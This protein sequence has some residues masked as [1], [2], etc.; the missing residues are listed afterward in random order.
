MAKRRSLAVT[1]ILSLVRKHNPA[2]PEDFKLLGIRLRK[3]GS[4]AFRTVYEIRGLPLV[5]KFP[6]PGTDF[7]L[8][9]I[10]TRTELARIK[11]FKKFRWMRKHLPRVY[12]SNPVTGVSIV[13]FVDDSRYMTDRGV[14]GNSQ[15]QR[16]QAMCNMAQELIY[17]LT[18]TRMTDIT[19]ENVRVDQKRRVIKLI[20]LAY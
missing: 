20:D 13:E 3:L 11:K 12:Y 9:K 19:D 1:R 8:N 6:L 15:Q 2:R 4:G 10:H 17:R 14:W 18:G 16:M 7:I 5:I